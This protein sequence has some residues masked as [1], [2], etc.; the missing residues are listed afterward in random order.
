MILIINFLHILLS[1]TQVSRLRK[2]FASNSSADIKLLKTQLHKIGQSGEF[3]G[4]LLGLLLKTGFIL[5]GNVLKLFAESV[6][7]PFGLTEAAATNA[8]INE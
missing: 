6:L 7:I 8:A 2:S 1:N 3:L 5:M 4:W